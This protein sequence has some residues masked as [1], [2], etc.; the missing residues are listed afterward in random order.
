MH[1]AGRQHHE[2]CVLSD[3]RSMQEGKAEESEREGVGTLPPQSRVG[4][5]VTSQAPAGHPKLLRKQGSFSHVLAASSAESY[6][7]E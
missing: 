3:I 6:G 7:G 1:Q 5:P 4:S 2:L